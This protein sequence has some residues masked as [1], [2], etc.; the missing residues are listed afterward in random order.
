M[1]TLITQHVHYIAL[2]QSHLQW[3]HVQ[4]FTSSSSS[5][6]STGSMLVGVEYTNYPVSDAILSCLPP[7]C[8]VCV[9]HCYTILSHCLSIFILRVC[10]DHCYTILS[11]CLSIFF[12][13]SSS[14]VWLLHCTKHH[15]FQQSVTWHSTYMTKENQLLL[16]NLSNYVPYTVTNLLKLAKVYL[17]NVFSITVVVLYLPNMNR[18]I[19]DTC[20][21]NNS[22][23]HI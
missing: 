12:L 15:W 1:F 6:S 10:V 5:S 3:P 11:H 20:K 19:T 9:D 7:S 8:W 18:Y 4:D 22:I 21:T 2:H 14:S 17:I 16:H 13:F 23:K